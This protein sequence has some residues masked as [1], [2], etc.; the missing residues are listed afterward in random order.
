MAIRFNFTPNGR[1]VEHLSDLLIMTF[2]KSYLVP[3]VLVGRFQDLDVGR[4][5]FETIFSFNPRRSFRIA[6]S[7]GMPFVFTW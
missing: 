3:T 1:R 6:T 2:V 4:C 7:V 5:G